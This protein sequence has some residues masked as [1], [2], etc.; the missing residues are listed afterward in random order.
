MRR[1]FL[2]TICFILLASP[3]FLA[4]PLSTALQ[5]TDSPQPIIRLAPALDEPQLSPQY[6][7]KP[8]VDFDQA[9]NLTDGVNVIIICVYFNDLNNELAIEE[10]EEF[11]DQMDQYYREASYGQ[12]WLNAEVIGWYLLDH[13]L[14]YYGRD[15]RMVDD[16]NYDGAIDSWK[17]LRDA[18]EVADP[19]VDFANYD[20]LMV[21]HAGFGQESSGN[22]N[23][24]WSV[25]Y[26]GSLWV[27]T[28]DQKSFYGGAI[29][30]E[31]EDRGA[32]ALGVACHELAHLIGL[33][34][35]YS[36]KGLRYVGRWGLMDRGLWNGDPAG[37][38]PAHPCAWSSL[39][40][41]WTSEDKIHTATL[42]SKTDTIV[43]PSGS[44]APDGQVQLVKIPLSSDGKEYH[45]IE[46]RS[47]IGFD[48]AL[49]GEGV[50]VYTVN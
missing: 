31:M 50:I 25:A 13:S 11:V 48:T 23:D 22:T 20:K 21:L 30:P 44:D 39:H 45:L 1:K 42:G 33:P 5:E 34:D 37:S 12:T 29:V 17:V 2:A 7:P 18:V 9:T 19:D 43:A 3:L 41:Q 27:R 47:H 28:K 6:S 36:T 24:I 16:T 14:S 8:V 40:L 4:I 32:S 38:S 49:P 10:V 26:I 35:L 15:G 46:V